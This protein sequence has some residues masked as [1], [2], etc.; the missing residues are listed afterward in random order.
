MSDVSGALSPA[1]VSGGSHRP[2][3]GSHLSHEEVPAQRSQGWSRT[4]ALAA[5]GPPGRRRPLPA[6]EGRCCGREGLALRLSL[7]WL[8]GELPVLCSWAS[9]WQAVLSLLFS[10]LHPGVLPS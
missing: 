3:C 5:L 8:W 10:C 1:P 9:G 7:G 6:G 2:H 4:G